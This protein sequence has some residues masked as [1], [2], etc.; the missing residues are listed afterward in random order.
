MIIYFELFSTWI[1]IWFIL[2]YLHLTNI[3]PLL[4]LIIAFIYAIFGL[5]FLI[6]KNASIIGIS[7]FISINILIKIIPIIL[8]I[9]SHKKFILNYLNIAFGLY[10]FLIYLSF[11][12]IILHKNPFYSYIYIINQFIYHK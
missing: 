2:Y 7:I 3:N 6:Y 8:I 4:Y 9:I 10:L 11:M 1:F 12:F 5:I